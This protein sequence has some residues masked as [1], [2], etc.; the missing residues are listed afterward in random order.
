MIPYKF[1]GAAIPLHRTSLTT[2]PDIGTLHVVYVLL[3]VYVHGCTIEIHVTKL[4]SCHTPDIYWHV[5]GSD[6]E[7][8]GLCSAALLQC[9]YLV[10]GTQACAVIVIHVQ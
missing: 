6:V 1:K 5:H 10:C 4:L 2:V 8:S 9:Q 7:P 3:V